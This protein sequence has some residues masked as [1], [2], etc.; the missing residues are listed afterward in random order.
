MPDG[1]PIKKVRC[2]LSLP[3]NR[4][5]RPDAEPKTSVTMSNNHSAYLYRNAGTGRWRIHVVPRFE[6]F[7]NRLVPDTQLRGLYAEEAEEFLFSVTPGCVVHLPGH[8]EAE[9][10]KVISF[11]TDGRIKMLPIND[12]TDARAVRFRA[13]R[14]SG[15][16][17]TK[18]VVLADG[19]LR[20][21]RD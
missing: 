8:E 15:L 10:W 11:E 5:L 7:K 13:S 12:S 20:T 14:L 16:D 18:V 21:A 2:H 17:A 6:A 3:G 19:Q 1:Q 9:L 4:V